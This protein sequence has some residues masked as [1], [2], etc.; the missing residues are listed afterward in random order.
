MQRFH[1]IAREIYLS[2]KESK[3]LI[4]V[5]VPLDK[6]FSE[7]SETKIFWFTPTEAFFD[8]LPD[9]IKKN[10]R[11]DFYS[12]TGN[13]ESSSCTYFEECRSTLKLDKFKIYPNP[14]KESITISF[15]ASEEVSGNIY[16]LDI[17]GSILKTFES[18]ANI[19][20]GSNEFHYTLDDIQPGIYLVAVQSENGIKTGRLIVSE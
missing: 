3:Y 17:K 9:R 1:S 7:Y 16:L 19:T 11:Q 4:P 13:L 12:L 18:I 8:R 5:R 10:L 6:Y 15:N 2:G 20:N 14:A